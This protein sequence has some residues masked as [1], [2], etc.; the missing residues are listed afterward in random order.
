MGKGR[1]IYIY[2][3]VGKARLAPQSDSVPLRVLLIAHADLRLVRA[4]LA[5]LAVRRVER[6]RERLGRLTKEGGA[7][8]RF[9]V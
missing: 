9:P 1:Y 5:V 3:Y 6:D 2:I 4:R 7:S 8:D